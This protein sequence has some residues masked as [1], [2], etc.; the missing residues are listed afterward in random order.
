MK[1]FFKSVVLLFQPPLILLLGI[2]IYF[3]TTP[4]FHPEQIVLYLL[5]QLTLLLVIIPFV[6]FL[7]YR[8][9]KIKKILSKTS[10]VRISLMS[11]GIIVFLVIKKVINV[12]DYPELYYFLLGILLSLL[13]VSFIL[14]SK[15][16]TSLTMIASSAVTMFTINLSIHFGIN[17][18]FLLVILININGLLAT[19]L[20][21]NK[22]RAVP[23]IVTGLI[24]GLI[25]QIIL[26][27][28]WL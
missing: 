21:F 27:I 5:L 28:H 17:L 25:P 19:S 23:E 1:Y 20:L 14:L 13:S 2:I 15:L 16:K 10:D 22:L 9:L 18:I 26:L 6:L 12:Y 24:L 7:I 4:R 8:R 11:Y 3:Y